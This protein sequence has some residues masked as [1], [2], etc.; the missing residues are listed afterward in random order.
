VP[1]LEQAFDHNFPQTNMVA[2]RASTAM[3]IAITG[4]QEK[5]LRISLF[6]LEKTERRS[7]IFPR[8]VIGRPLQGPMLDAL[9]EPIRDKRGRGK[10]SQRL[11]CG[12]L[13][14]NYGMGDR[15]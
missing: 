9:E 15:T 10:T 13:L 5:L 1:W 2:S 12:C 8:I 4:T 14:S 7:R 11:G 3:S 6:T